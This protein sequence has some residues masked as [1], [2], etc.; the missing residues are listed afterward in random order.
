[1]VSGAVTGQIL[2]HIVATFDAGGSERTNERT[3]DERTN[4]VIEAFPQSLFVPDMANAAAAA[5]TTAAVVV[6]SQKESN[7]KGANE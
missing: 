2:T 6:V 5:T 3:N 7:A 1:V 4:E